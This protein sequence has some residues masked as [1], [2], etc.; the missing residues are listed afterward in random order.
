MSKKA[1]G[2]KETGK[3]DAGKDEASKNEEAAVKFNA[4]KKL[5]LLKLKSELAATTKELTGLFAMK[6]PEFKTITT[7][8]ELETLIEAIDKGTASNNQMTKFIGIA[9]KILSKI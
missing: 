5:R 7:E 4:E 2:K 3:K 9:D 8:E 1:A 6:V